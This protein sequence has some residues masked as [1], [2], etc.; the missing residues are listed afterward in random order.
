LKEELRWI[1]DHIGGKPYGVDIL[2]PNEHAP[3]GD[4]K[5]DVSALP[6]EQTLFLRR[7]L[8][9]AGVPPL[10]A[11]E[12]EAMIK[13]EV[14]KVNMTREESEA[15]FDV[16]L[17]HPISMVVNAL[18][19]PSRAQVDRMHA[20]GVRVGAL[21]GKVEHALRQKAAGVDLLIAQGAEA[22]GHTGTI[23]SM[24]LWPQIIDAVAPLP[25]LAAGGVGRGKQMAA[26]LAMG[27]AGV[28]CGSIWLGT[29]QSDLLPEER[30]RLFAAG[31]EEAIQSRSRTGKPVRVL[32][33]RLTDAWERPDAP[34]VLPMPLQTLATMEARLRIARG[35]AKDF[36]S[37]PVGQVV[38]MMTHETSV[39]QIVYDMLSEFTDAVEALNAVVNAD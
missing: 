34:P 6:Q 23:S 22:G 1:D 32:R 38:A 21:V 2:M 15:L 3:L 27:A 18:G 11:G 17:E 33:S 10:P 37:P 14:A 35:R 9:D 8:D 4:A 25:V 13:A 16:C 36:M 30:E 12:A 19:V 29:Q 24:V 7:L 20:R 28:W 26:A 31:A 5:V 39:N